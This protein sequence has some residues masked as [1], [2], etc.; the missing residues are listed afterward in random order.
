VNVGDEWSSATESLGAAEKVLRLLEDDASTEPKKKLEEAAEVVA[1][2]KFQPRPSSRT[3]SSRL[4]HAT[5]TD[6]PVSGP[7]CFEG[8]TFGYPTDD[9]QPPKRPVLRDLTLTCPAGSTTALVG[10]SGCGKSTMAHLLQRLYDVNPGQGRITLDGCDLR[11]IDPTWLRR[12]LGVVGQEP[13]LFRGTVAEN[14]VW[15]LHDDDPAQPLRLRAEHAARAARAHDFVVQLPRGYDTPVADGKGLS[16]GERQ[17][18][19]L[20]RA[21]V[22]DP[23]ILLLDECT[24]ALDPVSDR[25]VTKALHEA[26]WCQRLGCDRTIVVIAHRLS[27]VQTADQIVV[28]EAGQV[29]E[30][31]SHEELIALGGAY[32]TL[33]ADPRLPTNHTPRV[34]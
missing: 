25:L 32:A 26:R 14:I 16:G 29:K 8:V 1:A 28:L 21:L 4:L 18:L 17:R 20:A 33:L 10:K 34:Q 15:G 22:R 24:S 6:M 2:E 12:N 9:G 5:A 27:T 30:A 31:G 13:R 11:D 7:I 23:P 19:A 3:S